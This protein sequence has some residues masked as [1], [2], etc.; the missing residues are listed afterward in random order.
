MNELVNKALK[1]FEGVCLCRDG[2]NDSPGHSARYC[3][4]TVMEHFT[5]VVVDFEVVDKRETGQFYYDGNGGTEKVVR[6]NGH[7]LSL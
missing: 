7:C 2:R 5:N 6:K 3:V 4:Y 1:D